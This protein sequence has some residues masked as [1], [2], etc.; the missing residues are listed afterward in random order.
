MASLIRLGL[1]TD[2]VMKGFGWEDICVKHNI[3][4]H[5]DKH[6]VRSFVLSYG[7]EKQKPFYAD[8]WRRASGFDAPAS[9]IWNRPN[10]P[11][12]SVPERQPARAGILDDHKRI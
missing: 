7:R 2:D 9:E 10:R 3:T 1:V 8:A 11:L 6:R 12:K 5:I 4:N